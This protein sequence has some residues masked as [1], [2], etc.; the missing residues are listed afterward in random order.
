MI[1]HE[2]T[3]V[4]SRLPAFEYAAS[5]VNSAAER[6]AFEGVPTEVQNLMRQMYPVGLDEQ[7]KVVMP[8]PFD[9]E[10]EVPVLMLKPGEDQFTLGSTLNEIE[11]ATRVVKRYGVSEV[12]NLD[13][14][15]MQGTVQVQQN[16]GAHVTHRLI[17]LT[18]SD[19][20]LQPF[21]AHIPSLMC[22]RIGRYHGS[23][24]EAVAHEAYH[25]W[26]YAHYIP[27]V[28]REHDVSLEQLHA[29]GE[30]RAYALQRGVEHNLGKVASYTAEDFMQEYE[31]QEHLPYTTG[32]ALRRHLRTPFSGLTVPEAVR[33]IEQIFGSPD[34][35]VTEDEVTALQ[36]IEVI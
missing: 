11:F 35:P 4:Q 30:K 20:Q 27:S 2:F 21:N 17:E 24:P 12:Y 34:A 6:G 26:D 18:P 22:F 23:M 31:G 9:Y 32:L 1:R 15:K 7:G 16:F 10:T 36:T 28:V 25:W 19:S 13:P 33:A 8:Q 5:A 29:L 3:D 14:E